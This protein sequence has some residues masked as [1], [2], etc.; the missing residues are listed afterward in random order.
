MDVQLKEMEWHLTEPEQW[1]LRA[2]AIGFGGTFMNAG[3]DE[4]IPSRCNEDRLHL[5][6][7]D[8]FCA[9]HMARLAA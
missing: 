2:R 8:I 5:H 4:P 6:L 9:V 3:R 1:V 7:L